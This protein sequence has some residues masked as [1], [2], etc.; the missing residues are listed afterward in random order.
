MLAYFER[1]AQ[2]YSKRWLRFT[3]LD[4]KGQLGNIDFTKPW[5]SIFTQRKAF[6]AFM[7][8]GRIVASVI[9]TLLPLFIGFA[10]SS[11]KFSSFG[12]LLLVWVCSE[13][14]RY[15]TLYF[16]SKF[17]ASIISGLR[18][19]AYK[20]FLT[21]DPIY[22]AT[23]MSGEIFGKIERCAFA[24][25]EFVDSAVYDILP[26]LVGMTTV[27]IS[28]FI[29]N[30]TL[31]LIAFCFIIFL[32]FLNSSMVLFNSLAFERRVIDADDAVKA[33]SMESLI[34]IQFIRSYFATN[35][36]N[37]GLKG[38][39]RFFMANDG[40][41]YISFHTAI[42]INRLF[43]A[44]S[45]CVIGLYV[46]SMIKQG[47]VSVVVGTT[48]LVTYIHGTYHIIKIG[49]RTQKFVRSIARI[50]DLFDFIRHFGTQTFPVLKG[51]IAQDYEIPTSDIISVEALDLYFA[52]FK[53]EIFDGHNLKIHVPYAQENK[54]YGII[55]P[56]GVGKTTLISILG[57][58]IK[59]DKG[60]VEVSDV[61]IYEVNDNVRRRLIA[62]QGQSASSLSGTLRYNLLL[63]VSKRSHVF[64]D[65][66]MIHILSKVGLWHIFSL[67]EG[68]DS[69]IGEGGFNLS[70]GQ[71]QRLNFAS[72]YLRTK[73]YKPL[74][75]MIDE[76]TSSLDEVSEY[77]ITDMIEDI[78]KDAL[79]FVIA[80]RLK[81]LDD[82]VGI[83]DLSLMEEEKDL[84]F[85]TRDELIK[86]S[87]Y[88]Q[89]LMRGE[90]TIE[91]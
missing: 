91:E 47:T 74:L 31:G 26:I 62:L 11:K 81:T 69:M 3:N 58:Q 56:S 66:L 44:V 39:S 5:W 57:G 89:K 41:Y 72:L 10:I 18:Y 23:K 1:L 53:A 46:L 71:R 32:A 12:F 84:I 24:Y 65:D 64:T 51:D 54:L 8:S 14:W 17:I 73:Y 27:I 78:A 87:E 25:E 6:V 55:G 28:F 45:L 75:V 79:V 42:Y 35:E 48:F 80:H 77:A 36:I 52:Y 38:K 20:F 85:Y 16:T 19:R 83:L 29:L 59:P 21:V 40:T 86:K 4:K 37:K 43:Y 49:K 13:S 33:S 68:L 15:I 90:V 60:E 67:K 30:L 50:T 34:Q 76:P 82:A 9:I 22:H 61:P 2:S 88:Y 63:G 7:L 70:V